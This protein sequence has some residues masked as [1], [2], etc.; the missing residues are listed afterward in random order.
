MNRAELFA[1]SSSSAFFHFKIHDIVNKTGCNQLMIV[2][3]VMAVLRVDIPH[4]KSALFMLHEK[5]QIM[6]PP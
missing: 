5:R 1:T 4:F 6:H 2:F 3:L